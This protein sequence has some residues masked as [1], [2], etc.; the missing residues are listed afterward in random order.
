MK[1]TLFSENTAVRFLHLRRFFRCAARW[2][3]VLAAAACIGEFYVLWQFSG[4]IAMLEAAAV[5]SNDYSAAPAASSIPD[6]ESPPCLDSTPAYAAGTYAAGYPDLYATPLP[7]QLPPEKTVY[8]TFDDGPSR[9][10]EAILDALAAHNAI[11]T[12]FVVGTQIEGH[13]D[14]LF[15]ILDSGST[16]ALHSNTHEYEEIYASPDA[17]LADLDALSEKIKASTGTAPDI[18][19]FAGG[20]VNSYDAGC[21]TELCAEVLRRGFRYYDWNVSAQDAVKKSPRAE[22]IAERVIHGVEALDAKTPAI[23]LMHDTK[24]TTA[25]ALPQILD[26]LFADGYRFAALDSSVPMITFGASEQFY[27]T[28]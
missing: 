24:A 2:V 19:R 7:V 6:S 1:T 26:A 4:K 15:R 16:L 18:V 25:A 11:G 12:W 5:P 22:V 20:S 3:A 27:S 13:E 10:T 28:D 17:F 23:V 21:E 8:L 9:N 14:T